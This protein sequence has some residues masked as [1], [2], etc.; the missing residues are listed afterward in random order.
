MEWIQG[1][2]AAVNYMEEHIL[3]DPD[4]NELG[5]LAG[6]SAHHFQRI[7]TYIGG[8]TLTEYIRKRRMSLAAVDLK[9]ENAK[10]I[11][12]AIKYGYDSP[13]AFNR[14]F[15]MIHGVTPTQARE[16][17]ITAIGMLKALRKSSK[18][19]ISISIISSDDIEQAQY[20]T[21][22]LT[23]VA[24]PKYEMGK[25]AVS[26]LLDRI[27]NGHSSVITMEFEGQ[28]KIRESCSDLN[29]SNMAYYI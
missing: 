22:M 15:R 9:D 5:K 7:F 29:D 23:T 11:D 26:L 4:L 8:I 20:T 16:T 17:D 3:E 2:N 1:M 21:P 13:T 12:V 18:K 24:L 19:H 6:C 14:A 27:K 28:L 25:F 10:V